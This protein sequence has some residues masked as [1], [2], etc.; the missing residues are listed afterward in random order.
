VHFFSG[1]DDFSYY[2]EEARR[3][4]DIAMRMVKLS[5]RKQ[6]GLGRWNLPAKACGSRCASSSVSFS[7][8]RPRRATTSSFLPVHRDFPLLVLGPPYPQVLGKKI[9]FVFLGSDHALPT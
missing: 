7:S 5:S 3:T 1:P 8:R 4:D 9:L 2:H 6:R